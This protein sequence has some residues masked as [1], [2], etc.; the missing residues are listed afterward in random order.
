MTNRYTVI[1]LQLYTNFYHVKKIFRHNLTYIR[2]ISTLFHNVYVTILVKESCY[3]NRY[4]IRRHE[5]D[6]F[7]SRSSHRSLFLSKKGNSWTILSGRKFELELHVKNQ[8]FSTLNFHRLPMSLY[9][10]NSVNS[11]ARNSFF[12]FKTG[13]NLTRN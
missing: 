13:Q 3:S 10:S 6:P 9:C 12:F 1:F 5:S 4:I 11:L 8:R 2:S 7:L